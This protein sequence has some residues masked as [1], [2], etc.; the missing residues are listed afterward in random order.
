M[1]KLALPLT[2][3][4]LLLVVYEALRIVN[5]DVVNMSGY[6]YLLAAFLIGFSVFVVRAIGFVLFDVVFMRRKGREAP[7]LLRGLL[8]T[9]L[10]C[11]FFLLIYRFVLKAQLGGFE[12]IATSTVVSVIVGL[13]LQDTLGNFFAGLSIH[14][15]QPF[16]I[17]DAIRIGDMLGRVE[18]VTWRTTAIRTNNNTVILLPN[19]KVAREPME[20]YQFNNLNRRVFSFPA[21][22]SIPPQRVFSIVRETVR[23]VPNVA[24]EKTPIVRI[25]NFSDSS[26]TYE[27]LYWVKDYMWIHDIDAKIREHIWYVYSRNEIDIPYPIRHV[28]FEQQE[29]RARSADAG[30]EKVIASVDIFEPLT[31]DE[32]EAVVKSLVKYAYAPGEAIIRCGEP[33]D[34]MFVICRGRVEVQ[35]PSNNGSLKQVAVLEPGNFFGEMALLTGEPRN[36]DVYALDEVEVLEIRKPVIQQ[37]F[38]ENAGLAEALSHRIT[39]RQAGLAEH[40]R[41][42]TEDVKQARKE[43]ILRRI[44]RFFSLS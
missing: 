16:H 4:V 31:F 8:S 43:T 6:A 35:L 44:K 19:S 42:M 34:S 25:S 7:A 23:T 32:R 15:E 18:A 30:Y 29:P 41:A 20:I 39:E 24:A 12:F 27:I 14:I 9:V 33:G 5:P 38:D 21:P 26:I 11:V 17:L 2:L 13:A 37:L 22:Y 36:A 1:K 40:S 10:Y 28:L 3:T